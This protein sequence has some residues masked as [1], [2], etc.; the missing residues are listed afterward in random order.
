MTDKSAEL[1]NYNARNCH[2]WT[3]LYMHIMQRPERII[4]QRSYNLLNIVFNELVHV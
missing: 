3:Q 2:E 4:I 1:C